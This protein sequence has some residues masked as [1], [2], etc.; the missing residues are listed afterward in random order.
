MTASADL[1]KR[2]A[3]L[4]ADLALTRTLLAQEERK[5]RRQKML[6]SRLPEILD[7]NLTYRPVAKV[8]MGASHTFA[9]NFDVDDLRTSF[10]DH[11]VVMVSQMV[12]RKGQVTLIGLDSENRHNYC[13]PTVAVTFLVSSNEVSDLLN[14]LAE[15]E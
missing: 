8:I 14:A 3:S 5:E 6:Q 2:I 13:N 1:H 12:E 7:L 15:S 9:D 11:T 10:N 4:E